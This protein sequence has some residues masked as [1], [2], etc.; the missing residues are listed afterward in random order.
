MTRVAYLLKKF[1]RLSETFVLGEILTQEALGTEVHVF[2]RREPDDEPRHPQL[3]ALRAEVEVLPSIRSIDPWRSLFA[4]EGGAGPLLARI[5]ELCAFGP[6]RAHPRFGSLV[7]EALHL[8]QRTRELGIE[9]VHA[10]FA[11]DSAVAAMILAALGGPGYS[12]TAHAKDIYR[13]GVDPDL[14]DL[15]VARS[16]FTVTVCDANVRH[17]EGLVGEEARGR[18]RRLYNGIDLAAF[19]REPRADEARDPAHV[20]AVGR[21]VEKK[22]FGVLLDA[23]ARLDREGV[24]FTATIVGDGE[25]REALVARAAVH[26]LGHRVEFTGPRDQ[27]HVRDLMRRAT[28]LCL[29]CLVGTDGNRDALPTVLLE[30]LASG[31]PCISTPV[32]GIPEILDGGRA[33]AIVPCEDPDRT[34][35]ALTELLAD[36]GRRAVL[37]SRGR[38]RAERLFDRD[39]QGAVLR[40]WFEAAARGARERRAEEEARCAS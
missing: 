13:E 11:T 39:R 30:A 6:C 15:L 35:D 4:A 10:H 34:A 18:L 27:D 14:L 7:A 37:A 22:G 1:P 31:L 20:L 16:A 28:V 19:A 29:P 9:H 33:G 32:S 23:L 36:P 8:L 25:E 2:S 38:A 26:G 40:D 21:L 5:E 12:I 24:P 17:V 3:A